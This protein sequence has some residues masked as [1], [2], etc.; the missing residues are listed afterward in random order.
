[1]TRTWT[2]VAVPAR[3][4]ARQYDL[5]RNNWLT[6]FDKIFDDAFKAVSP[7]IYK[8]FGIEPFSK[9]AYPKVNVVA[10][11]DRVEIEAEIAGYA[12]DDISV[13]VESKVLSIVGKTN[14]SHEPEVEEEG[15]DGV[16][17]LRELKRSSFSRS[18]NLSDELETDGIEAEFKNGLLHITIPRK[19]EVQ[20][21]DP[22]VKKV[23]IK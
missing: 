18:F 4:A 12:K 9:A 21:W 2:R 13:E 14:S 11:R 16:Y 7:D 10:H 5:N 6:A 20:R 22:V 15:D 3:V 23:T 8:S 1:M 19:E 17:I